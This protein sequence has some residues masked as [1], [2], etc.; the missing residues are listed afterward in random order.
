MKKKTRRSLL[1]TNEKENN[2]IELGKSLGDSVIETLRIQHTSKSVKKTVVPRSTTYE[3]L[4]SKESMKRI[5]DSLRE[6]AKIVALQAEAKREREKKK[7]EN[8]QKQKEL[9]DM[10]AQNKE[11]R[12][13]DQE[14]KAE[15]QAKKH[16]KRNLM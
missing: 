4:T 16:W 13:R 12:A 10:R 14:K 2:F 3:A 1:H 15:D 9:K 8:K 11:K 6:K 5:A 7:E